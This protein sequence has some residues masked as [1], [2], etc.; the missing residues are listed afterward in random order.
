MVDQTE[1][2][3]IAKPKSKRWRWFTLAIVISVLTGFALIPSPPDEFESL[4]R[5]RP[6]K[7]TSAL[8][9]YDQLR[10]PTNKLLP[11]RVFLDRSFVFSRITPEINAELASLKKKG[12]VNLTSI[13]ELQEF[14]SDTRVQLRFHT[15]PPPTWIEKQWTATRNFLGF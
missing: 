10:D 5:L 6:I 4:R 14:D 7:E 9:H 11:R 1:A 13:M 8:Y 12:K 2:P 15:K 3:P